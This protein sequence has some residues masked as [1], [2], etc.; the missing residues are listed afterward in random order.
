MSLE[1][2][3]YSES[4][5]L[6]RVE[7]L[8]LAVVHHQLSNE[9]LR[10]Q[11]NQL[12]PAFQFHHRKDYIYNTPIQAFRKT[13]SCLNL[14]AWKSR[15]VSSSLLKKFVTELQQRYLPSQDRDLKQ[16]IQNE[17]QNARSLHTG[18][19]AV[20]QHYAKSLLIRIDLYFSAEAQVDLTIRHCHQHLKTLLNRLSNRDGCFQD[21]H[22]WAWALEQGAQRGYHIHL[23]LVYDGHKHQNDQHLAL[24][25]GNYWKD[26]LTAGKGAFYT[27]NQSKD[28][29]LYRKMGC[30]GIGMIHRDVAVE[31]GNALKT[32]SYLAVSEKKTIQMLRVKLPRM[33]S[34]GTAQFDVSWRRGI[35]RSA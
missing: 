16:H 11:L 32:A 21:L 33:R 23:V 22:W 6:I 29:D 15:N 35:Q 26:V 9:E 5:C 8:V 1:Y 25:V 31:V 10:T 17:Q 18:L 30:L 12:I 24:Q 34:F 13:L 2:S 19:S 28:K 14:T 27:A 4:I 20:L 3:L 7:S